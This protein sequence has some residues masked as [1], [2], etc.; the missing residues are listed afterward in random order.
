MV[1]TAHQHSQ[2]QKNHRSVARL[3]K[4]NRVID[5]VVRIEQ[6]TG[7]PANILVTH[8]PDGTTSIEASA[9]DPLIVKD[10]KNAAKIETAQFAIPAD[11]KDIKTAIDLKVNE[12]K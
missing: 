12:W 4:E 8:N 6:A 5:S 11:I 1:T 3:L 9:V 10:E 2:P 7:E